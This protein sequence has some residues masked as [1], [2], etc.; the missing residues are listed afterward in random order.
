ML[1]NPIPV[2]LEMRETLQLNQEQVT[3]ITAISDRLQ[4]T[5][6]RRREELGRRF[7][8]VQGQ[9]GMQLFAQLQPEIERSRNEIRTALQQ[10]ERIMTREQWNQVPERVRNPFQQQGG[11]GGGQGVR[12]G[13]GL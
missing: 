10:V 3:Q 11:P 6:N 1:V 12:R 13:G 5:L 2:M 7:D 9:Q 4:E 8:N